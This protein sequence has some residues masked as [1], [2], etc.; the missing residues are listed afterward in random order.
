MDP[1]SKVEIQNNF[2]IKISCN[3]SGKEELKRIKA[4]PTYDKLIEV[5]QKI[6]NVSL[7]F[8][9]LK[10]YYIDEDDDTVNISNQNDY[11][12]ALDYISNALL[13]N[14]SFTLKILLREKE[15]ISLY[16]RSIKEQFNYK[17]NLLS[18]IP[19]C[20][21]SQ[22]NNQ[23]GEEQINLILMSQNLSKNSQ[24]LRIFI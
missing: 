19:I 14:Q 13:Q 15:E 21:E 5:I 12:Q 10:C 17:N 23:Q 7:N 4:P 24:S 6:F 22:Q 8:S 9:A 1:N 18:D 20:A 2:F 3:L 16:Q 11:D